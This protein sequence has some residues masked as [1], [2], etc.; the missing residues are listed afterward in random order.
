MFLKKKTLRK[1]DRVGRAYT[2]LGVW[3]SKRFLILPI[4]ER[5]FAAEDAGSPTPAISR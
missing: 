2:S 1:S 3:L 4:W 5:G